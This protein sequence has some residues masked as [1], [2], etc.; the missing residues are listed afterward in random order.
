LIGVV[1]AQPRNLEKR[2]ELT[3]LRIAENEKKGKKAE[4][5]PDREAQDGLRTVGRAASVAWISGL[6]KEVD[7]DTLARVYPHEDRSPTEGGEEGRGEDDED[8][9]RSH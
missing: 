4:A 3:G 2:N 7:P 6:L 8:S 9:V 5:R 1:G